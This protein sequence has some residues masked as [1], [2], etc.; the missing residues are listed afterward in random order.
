M[1]VICKLWVGTGT[2]VL[3]RVGLTYC[4]YI[5]EIGLKASGKPT[6]QSTIYVY[7]FLPK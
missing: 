4:H 6:W 5:T 2:H 7:I 1:P 3:N